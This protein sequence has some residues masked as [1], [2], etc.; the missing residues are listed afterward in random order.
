MKGFCRDC[1]VPLTGLNN[2]GIKEARKCPDCFKGDSRQW[3]ASH[4][5]KILAGQKKSRLR[6]RE[7]V[8]SR[9]GMKCACCGEAREEFLSIDHPSGDGAAHRRSIGLT[10]GDPFYRWLRANGFPPGFRTL[11]MNCNTS[12]GFHGYCP[13]E[14]ES[15]T[16]GAP[17][18]VES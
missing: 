11:C 8:L 4:M 7:E 10:S 1:G 2:R 3:A 13:H 17:H 9:Y 16:Y 14:R 15:L 12:F 18:N 6:L 5:P